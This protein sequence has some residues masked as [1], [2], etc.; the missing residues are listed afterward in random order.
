MKKLVMRAQV[1]LLSFVLCTNLAYAQESNDSSAVILDDQ[2]AEVVENDMP[3]EDAE[4]TLDVIAPADEPAD[5][6]TEEPAD[7][8]ADESAEESADELAGVS[9]EGSAEE[10]AEDGNLLDVADDQ[11]GEEDPGV[12]EEALVEDATPEELAIEELNA[13]NPNPAASVEP[14]EPIVAEEEAAPK[15]DAGSL[16]AQAEKSL[17]LSVRYRAHV[18]REGWQKWSSDG[19]VAGTSG[20]ALRMEAFRI[21]LRGAN[22]KRVKG[23]SYRTHVQN[24]G[25]QG[26]KNDGALAGTQ[27]RGLRAEALR[28]KLT[29][30]L[31]KKYDV[32]YRVHIQRYGWLGWAKNGAAA[33][34]SGKS[35]RVEALCVRLVPKGG[36]A[37]GS[38]KRPFVDGV[39]ITLEGLVQQ[40][41][42]VS[43]NTSVG[44]VGRGLRIEAIKA[45]LGGA[46][47]TGSVYYRAHVQGIG[48]QDEVKN[49]AMAGTSGESRRVEAITMRL[50]GEAEKHYDVWYRLHVQRFGWLGWAKNGGCAGTAGFALRA[51]S[52]QVQVRP[53]GSTQPSSDDSSWDVP[54]VAAP[55]LSVSA[56]LSGGRWLSAKSSGQTVG[57][58]KKGKAVEQL[59]MSVACPD[60]ALQG[61]IVYRVRPTGG[62][63]SS[64]VRNGSDAGNSGTA[65]EGVRISLTGGLKRVCDVWYRA[66]LSEY[67]WLAWV[68]GSKRAGTEGTGSIVEALQVKVVPKG[69]VPAKSA[70]ARPEGWLTVDNLSEDGQALADAN[71]LQ[72]RLVQ[73]AYD[74]PA[75]PA[76]YCAMWVQNV[77]ANA[78][79]GQ[80]YGDA[81]DLYDRYC[82][83][84]NLSELKAGMIVAVSTHPHTSA[85]S[86]WGHVGVFV[87]DGTVRDSVYGYVR[88]STLKD[89]MDYYGATVPVKWGWLGGVNVA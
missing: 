79:F 26:W 35:L 66:Y 10:L 84:A 3:N 64:V 42:W 69:E 29:G 17:T 68:K 37:P 16:E 80:F 14:S 7:D 88:T 39:R 65:I 71:A 47:Y 19:K 27:G 74:T 5:D 81:C 73:S 57:S 12:Q 33:G 23:I 22:G 77:Y 72:R 4:E 15:R 48:W 43:G 36:A 20:E 54:Y 70:T 51:E 63:W 24:I 89:W 62:E 78:G 44:T 6:S 82:T 56:R 31:A 67:G 2:M 11:L 87:G 83:S 30:D 28:I 38:T 85:G 32:W 52:V 75:A 46:Q 58:T 61:G 50:G 45:R 49:G 1:F 21:E 86:I 9:D 55:K 25:W 53:K 41:G 18:Q 60:D 8:S 76:G 59:R 34:S 13:E 40:I